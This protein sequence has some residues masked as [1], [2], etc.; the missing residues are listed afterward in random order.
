MKT[1]E[2][3]KELLDYAECGSTPIIA[4]QIKE[5]YNAFANR[6]DLYT[7]ELSS[8]QK[9]IWSS[10]N[11]PAHLQNNSIQYSLESYIKNILLQDEGIP[12]FSELAIKLVQYEKMYN[13]STLLNELNE[14]EKKKYLKLLRE[15]RDIIKTH[16][17][18][19]K[20]Y[21][22]VLMLYK[23]KLICDL[24][25]ANKDSF[26][27][28]NLYLGNE[29]MEHFIERVAKELKKTGITTAGNMANN[30]SSNK[31]ASSDVTRANEI[32]QKTSKNTVDKTLSNSKEVQN[33][34]QDVEKK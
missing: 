2:M 15:L 20:D 10:F 18:K 9:I 22:T 3:L 28:P 32:L 17:L 33:N 7:D 31:L 6:D 1:K 29:T 21:R 27:A 12:F 26:F 14:E 11:I 13:F 4:E 8:F 19:I 24:Y 30:D 25:T 34:E 16:F 5:K 23:L